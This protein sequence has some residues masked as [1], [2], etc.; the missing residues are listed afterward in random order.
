[1]QPLYDLHTNSR[2]MVHASTWIPGGESG[3]KASNEE[4]ARRRCHVTYQIP[5]TIPCLLLKLTFALNSTTIPSQPQICFDKHE[6]L[7]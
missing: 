5:C 4:K 3:Y 2:F 1:M 7:Y 6:N